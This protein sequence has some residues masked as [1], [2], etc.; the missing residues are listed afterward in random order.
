MIIILTIFFI[1]G[2]II[3]GLFI[4]NLI[5]S[6]S[7]L[8]P[9][10]NKKNKIDVNDIKRKWILFFA[11]FTLVSSIL[12]TINISMFHTKAITFSIIITIFISIMTDILTITYIGPYFNRNKEIFINDWRRKWIL[13]FNW[14]TVGSWIVALILI[15][16]FK[17]HYIK[18]IN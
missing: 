13:F 11:W 10:F 12:Y 4:T 8:G 5:F 2:L 14:F 18:I 6:I 1:I 7:Y 15:L 9:T 17:K 3:L 16:L